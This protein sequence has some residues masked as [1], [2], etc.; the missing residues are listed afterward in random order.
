MRDRAGIVYLSESQPESVIVERRLTRPQPKRA[1]WPRP[2]F[3]NAGN[4]ILADGIR[5][6]PGPDA[7]D[8]MTRVTQGRRPPQ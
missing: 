2:K 5:E 3:I 7:G 6:R 1:P 8:L 4:L